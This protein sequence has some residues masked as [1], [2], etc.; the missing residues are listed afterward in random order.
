MM[1]AYRKQACPDITCW[2]AI[3]G[4]LAKQ[5]L[6]RKLTIVQ[7]IVDTRRESNSEIN[8]EFEQCL[9]RATF[10]GYPLLKWATQLEMSTKL[11][12]FLIEA[13]FT[14]GGTSKISEGPASIISLV[15]DDRRWAF[16]DVQFLIRKGHDV[17]KYD[18]NNSSSNR[19]RGSPFYVALRSHRYDI[20]K[21]LLLNGAQALPADPVNLDYLIRQYPSA[22]RTCYLLITCNS[23]L[24]VAVEGETLFRHFLKDR[25]SGYPYVHDYQPMILLI[26]DKIDIFCY[27]DRKA[28][29]DY[30]NDKLLPNEILEKIH[31]ILYEPDSLMNICRKRL[32]RHYRCHFHRFINIIVDEAFPKS[33]T[34]YLQCKDLL[35]KYFPVTF[36]MENYKTKYCTGALW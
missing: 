8:V 28:L 21:L 11:R 7:T 10:N 22:R 36:C 9:M 26:L 12:R 6:D 19:Y 13:G 25:R 20:A 17:N 18:Q 14:P 2:Y 1:N 32:H 31:T 23:L 15:I 4:L 16:E 30:Q 29:L 27:E 24:S 3:Q 34:D 35:L 5:V 33:I